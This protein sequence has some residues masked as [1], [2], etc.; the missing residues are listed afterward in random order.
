MLRN[1][2]RW[3][4]GGLVLLTALTLVGVQAWSNPETHDTNRND[5]AKHMAELIKQGQLNLSQATEIAEKHT[6]GVALEARCNLEPVTADRE[7][8]TPQRDPSAGDR[9]V[10][11]VEC[12]A[13]EKLSTVRVDGMSKKVIEGR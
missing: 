3:G 2:S 13:K 12:F 5:R 7:N 8:E 6:N 4:F 10:Y 9:L 11:S 1:G